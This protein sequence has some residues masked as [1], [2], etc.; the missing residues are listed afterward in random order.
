[1]LN[2]TLFGARAS[3]HYLARFSTDLLYSIQSIIP[4][5]MAFKK[6]ILPALA[7]ATSV[8]GTSDV[9]ASE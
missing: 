8:L 9:P 6:F 3:L 2:T 7:L 1:V 4:S 5:T